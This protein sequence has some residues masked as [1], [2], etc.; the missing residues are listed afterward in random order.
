MILECIQYWI[1][2]GFAYIDIRKYKNS[3]IGTEFRK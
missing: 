1:F 3:I 2:W